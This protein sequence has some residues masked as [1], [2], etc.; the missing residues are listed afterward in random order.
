[1]LGCGRSGDAVEEAED[2]LDELEYYK[3]EEEV[4]LQD[5]KV[6][7]SLHKYKASLSSSLTTHLTLGL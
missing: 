6:G 5:N 7:G 4:K 3:L 2:A 1:M